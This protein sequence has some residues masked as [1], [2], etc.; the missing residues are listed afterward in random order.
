MTTSERSEELIFGILEFMGKLGQGFVRG[1]NEM[2]EFRVGPKICAS[3]SS[4]AERAA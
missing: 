1:A 2:G 3:N 4:E